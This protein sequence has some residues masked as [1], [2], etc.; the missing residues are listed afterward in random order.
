MTSQKGN[1]ICFA[2]A[3][4]D[5]GTDYLRWIG[6]QGQIIYYYTPF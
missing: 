2:E 1:R 4:T 6:G 5:P 3:P